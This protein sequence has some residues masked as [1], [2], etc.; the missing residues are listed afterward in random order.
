M[1]AAGEQ[2]KIEKAKKIIRGAVIG[3]IITVGAYSITAFI[4]P[5]VLER[6][7]G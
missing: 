3:L 7:A 6:A 4:V 2:E 1:T 5:R